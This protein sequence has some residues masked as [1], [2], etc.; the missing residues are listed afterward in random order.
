M[1]EEDYYDV[2]NVSSIGLTLQELLEYY[3]TLCQQ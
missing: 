2:A 1:A 3:R